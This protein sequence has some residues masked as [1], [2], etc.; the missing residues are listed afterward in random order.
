MKLAARAPLLALALTLAAAPAAGAQEAPE[1]PREAFLA[2]LRQRLGRHRYFAKIP[3]E[4][5]DDGGRVVLLVQKPSLERPN[6]AASLRN[7]YGAW[8]EE[9]VEIFDRRYVGPLELSGPDPSV[10]HVLAVLETEG[11]LVNYGKVALGKHATLQ[12]PYHDPTLGFAVCDANFGSE[13]GHRKRFEALRAFALGLLQRHH[14]GEGYPPSSWL[15]YGMAEY[16]SFHLGTRPEGLA[17]PRMDT[18]TLEALVVAVYDAKERRFL[19]HALQDMVGLRDGRELIAHVRMKAS[20]MNKKPDVANRSMGLFYQASTVWMHFLQ[21]GSAGR[22]SESFADYFA[23]ALAGD[24]SVDAFRKA[25]EGVR[26][27]TLEREFYDFVFES[28]ARQRPGWTPEPEVLD[29]FFGLAGGPEESPVPAREAPFST[30]ALAFDPADHQVRHA[31]AVARARAGDLTAAAADLETALGEAEGSAFEGRMRRELERVQTFARLRDAFFA[32]LVEDRGRLTLE[33]EGK[34]L[35]LRVERVEEGIVYFADNR[36]DL[37][38]LPL[39]GIRPFEVA[40][41]LPRALTRGEEGWARYYPYVLEGDERWEK[42]EGDG[43]AEL[44]RDDASEWYPGLLKLGEAA[45]LVDE[46]VAAGLPQGKGS[47]V[48]AL[49]RIETLTRDFAGLELVEARREA[50]GTL[51]SRALEGV[52]RHRPGPRGPRG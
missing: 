36:H 2:D 28:Y 14:A 4:L 20:R 1:S 33:Q 48:E 5:V 9:L 26:L 24:A 27:A 17:T 39:D 38:A 52:L 45:A 49:A 29:R 22:Y 37:D 50:L 15:T 19:L 42:L 7:F 40:R 35:R 6:Y 46:L 43:P 21:H 23:S 25:F 41:Q 32:G 51:A 16:L 47:A 12:S 44:L 8:C 10:P 30:E 18:A 3:Y 34:S 31:L 13:A 11:D